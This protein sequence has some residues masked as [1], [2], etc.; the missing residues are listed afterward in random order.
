MSRWSR[1]SHGS[2]GCVLRGC[3]PKALLSLTELMAMARTAASQGIRFG[4]PTIDLEAMRTWKDK[5]VTQLADGL[6]HLCAQRSVR[7]V[8][9]RATFTR[10]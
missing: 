10:D 6:A 3:I 7:L 8:Q 2:V 5:V 9:A 1:T 4:E